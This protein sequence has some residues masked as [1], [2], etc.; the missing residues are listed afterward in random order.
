[1]EIKTTKE[2]VQE[3]LNSEF[4]TCDKKWIS[5]ISLI[6]ELKDCII[7]EYHVNVGFNIDKFNNILKE[8]DKE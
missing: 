1:M 3:L 6:K 7:D 5:R 2:I 8:L 4:Y